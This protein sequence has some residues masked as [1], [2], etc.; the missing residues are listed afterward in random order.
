MH[1]KM[2]CFAFLLFNI[3]FTMYL[4]FAGDFITGLH[5]MAQ[6]MVNSMKTSFHPCEINLN[7]V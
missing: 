1:G 7:L 2:S 3:H 4:T 5:L 6:Q